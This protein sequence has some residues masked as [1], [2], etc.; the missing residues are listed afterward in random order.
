MKEY[1]KNAIKAAEEDVE[2][3]KTLVADL[4]K[5]LDWAMTRCVDASVIYDIRKDLDSKRQDLYLAIGRLNDLYREWRYLDCDDDY[6]IHEE[7][8]DSLSE[9]YELYQDYL[10]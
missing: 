1:L 4:D 7:S 9:E 6:S 2:K 10:E 8:I 3:A 5:Q